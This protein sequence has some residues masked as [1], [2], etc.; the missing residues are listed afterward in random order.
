[1]MSQYGPLLFDGPCVPPPVGP[2]VLQCSANV[3]NTGPRTVILSATDR[4]GHAASV[5]E[6]PPGQTLTLSPPPT[7]AWILGMAE[8][9]GAGRALEDWGLVGLGVLGLAVYGGVK[10]VQ[11]H[12]NR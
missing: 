12:H 7:G 5:F 8:A 3:T 4:A 2:L 6:I 10:I 1:M 11:G 9:R